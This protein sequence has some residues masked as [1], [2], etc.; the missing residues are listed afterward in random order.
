MFN[1]Q[2][3][4]AFTDPHGTISLSARIMLNGQQVETHL[5][6]ADAE[7]QSALVRIPGRYDLAVPF[8]NILNVALKY[9]NGEIIE[10]FGRP[11]TTRPES[12]AYIEGVQYA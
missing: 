4:S 1:S 7:T 6:D 10:N 3:P 5:L 11:T 12:I 9:S 8:S 2:Y